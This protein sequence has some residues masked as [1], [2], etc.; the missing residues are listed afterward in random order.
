[1]RLQQP[2][3]IL[4]KQNSLVN[5]AYQRG[6]LRIESMVERLLQHA[7]SIF[8]DL[9]PKKKQLYVTES[10]Y[11]LRLGPELFASK[12]SSTF[13]KRAVAASM[14]ASSRQKKKKQ[15]IVMLE[16]EVI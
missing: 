12:P 14:T 9:A 13:K 8:K 10:Y 3:K 15:L 4:P 6:H 2:T 5:M 7:I 1:M 16:Y 11:L